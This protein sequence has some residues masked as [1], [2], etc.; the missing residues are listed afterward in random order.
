VIER[1]D[2][3]P[4]RFFLEHQRII[5]EWANLSKE[6]QRV[7]QSIMKKLAAELGERTPTDAEIWTGNAGGSY[8][9]AVYYKPN[10]NTIAD[11][12]P[13][14][15]VGLVWSDSLQLG[16]NA[17]MIGIRVNEH[18]ADSQ[19]V[20]VGLDECSNDLAKVG[21]KPGRNWAS[22]PAW[23]TLEDPEW[24]FW[25]DLSSWTNSVLSSVEQAYATVSP[26]LDQLAE[27]SR[28]ENHDG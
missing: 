18:L 19:R 22:W 12:E 8:T 24:G 10:W 25:D 9:M 13:S 5:E 20:R 23:G 28:S 14:F 4:V 17:P 11:G 27:G 15:G 7:S 21:L 6:V 16:T 2:D 26:L 1:I 3:E